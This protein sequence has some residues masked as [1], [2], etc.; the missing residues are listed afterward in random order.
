M[1]SWELLLQY[2][3]FEVEVQLRSLRFRSCDLP[4][5]DTT[6]NFYDGIPRQTVLYEFMFSITEP[7]LRG[8]SN[9]VEI[10]CVEECGKPLHSLQLC[11]IHLLRWSVLEM[12][13][14][15]GE[16]QRSWYSSSHSDKK[17]PCEALPSLIHLIAQQGSACAFL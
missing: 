3:S 17:F 1:Q 13:P 5:T 7:S 4:T 14:V 6:C 11:F 2:I 9:Q 15:P 16:A 10:F 12:L 8:D